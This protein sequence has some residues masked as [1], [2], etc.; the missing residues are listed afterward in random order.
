M[1]VAVGKSACLF[2]VKTKILGNRVMNALPKSAYD[3]VAHTIYGLLPIATVIIVI[4]LL[5]VSI[6]GVHKS[7]TSGRRDNKTSYGGAQYFWTLS[8]QL[9]SSHPPGA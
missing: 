8:T 6:R 4:L 5:C 2:I 1:H 9:A 3:G 7:L